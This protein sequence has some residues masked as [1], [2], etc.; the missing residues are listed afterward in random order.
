METLNS[1]VLGHLTGIEIE[2]M[3]IFSKSFMNIFLLSKLTVYLKLFEVKFK[4]YIV[5]QIPSLWL[6]IFATNRSV[7]NVNLLIS[8]YLFCIYRAKC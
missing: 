5:F 2:R 3:W 8:K 6:Q 1:L 7:F 4:K